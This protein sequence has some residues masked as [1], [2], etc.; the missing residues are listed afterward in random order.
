MKKNLYR[1]LRK[2]QQKRMDAVIEKYCFFA[3]SDA[4]FEEGMKKFGLTTQP[5]DLKKISRFYAGGYIL[6]EHASELHAV[7]ER[8][9]QDFN[10]AVQDP[11]N[12]EE[13]L[14]DAFTTS[15]FDHEFAVSG[16]AEDA[17]DSLGMSLE[18]IRKDPK[19]YRV[20]Q[21]SMEYVI[22]NTV[23]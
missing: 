3:F 20:L 23:F 16:S 1:S 4:Q 7:I 6:K 2:I 11:V 9:Q 19:Q 21:E 8:N 17:L 5:E 12:G 22:E 14:R 13:F 10:E 15:L 18:E